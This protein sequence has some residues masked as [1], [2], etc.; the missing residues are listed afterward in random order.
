MPGMNKL[1]RTIGPA[2]LAAP[3]LLLAMALPA[4]A[5]PASHAAPDRRTSDSA[6][7]ITSQPGYQVFTHGL[8]GQITTA[9]GTGTLFYLQAS[10]PGVWK[11]K[12][13]GT[14]DHCLSDMNT[15]VDVETCAPGDSR[16]QWVFGAAGTGSGCIIT[17]VAHQY[18][19]DWG[20]YPSPPAGPVWDD[21]QTGTGWRSFRSNNGISC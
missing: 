10:S 4:S 15:P 18:S 6:I 13:T 2:V 7:W 3:A 11:I 1:L 17:S 16:Q 12:V 19:R 5:S 9:S 8:G 14:T 21:G 20:V